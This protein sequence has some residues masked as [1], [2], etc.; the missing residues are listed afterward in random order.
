M[1]RAKIS[2]IILSLVLLFVCT[3]G[4]ARL[5][6]ST[7]EAAYGGGVYDLLTPEL[8]EV[9]EREISE[10]PVV[11]DKPAAMISRVAKT[12][13]ISEAKLKTIML[14]QDLAARMDEDV[15]LSRLAEMSDLELLI[16]AKDRGTAYAAKLPPERRQELKNMLLAAL[17]A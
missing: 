15:S 1:N 4:T 7:E 10:G 8:I 2:V 6:A 9:Y 5:F 17:K 3:I 14:I 11:S 13:D 16:Y 12:L